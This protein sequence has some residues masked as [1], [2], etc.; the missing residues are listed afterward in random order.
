V[1]SEDIGILEIDV[2]STRMQRIFDLELYT[3]TRRVVC[4]LDYKA[5]AGAPAGA[6]SSGGAPVLR[7]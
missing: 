7:F 2:L 1:S 6:N 5:P 4:L 3:V